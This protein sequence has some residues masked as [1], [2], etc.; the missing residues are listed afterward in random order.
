MATKF[1][2]SQFKSG[3]LSQ[4]LDIQLQDTTSY[5]AVNYSDGAPAL[6]VQDNTVDSISLTSKDNTQYISV[7]DA[8]IQISNGSGLAFAFASEG[9]RLYDPSDSSHYVELKAPSISSNVTLTLPATDG[10]VGQVLTTDG[11]G[12]LSWEDA[13]SGSSSSGSAGAVQI[14]NGSGGFTSEEANFFYNTSTN[15]VLIAN[16]TSGNYNLQVTSDNGGIQISPVTSGLSGALNAINVTGSTTGNLNIG[17]TNSNAGSGANSR[18]SLNTASGAG[19]PFILFNVGDTGYVAGIDNSDSDT[20][21]IGIGSNPSTMTSNSINIRGNKVGVSGQTSPTAALHLPAGT[22][23]AETAPLKFTTG[24]AMTTPEDGAL[25]Y[26]SSHLYFTIGSTRYQLDQQVAGGGTPI[27]QNGNSLGAAMTIGTNDAYALNLETNGNTRI[28]VSSAGEIDLGQSGTQRIL[29]RTAASSSSGGVEIS[30]TSTSSTT[31]VATKITGPSYTASSNDNKTVQITNSYTRSSGASGAVTAL[32]INPTVNLS[33]S[34]AGA[35]V[36]IDVTP[37]LTSLTGNFYGLYLNYSNAN[38]FGIFQ[39]GASTLNV[40]NGKLALGS[41]TS[42]TEALNV[43]GNAVVAGQYVSTAFGITDGAGFTVNWNNGNVQ[44]VT[45]QA[46]RTPTFSNPK[47]GGRY[48]LIVIQG[49]GGSK[50]ITWPTI[51]WRG[52][53]APTLTTAAGK[54]DIITLVYA[55]GSY[56]GDASLNY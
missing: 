56:Y 3:I 23:S 34:A 48:I 41:T 51:K 21:R 36:G 13:V 44:Y 27:V 20:F 35:S 15:Q 31:D 1:N 9:F 30:S 29:L 24:T 7:L 28:S 6:Y 54:A 46:N 38:A 11:S 37:T 43:T 39:S 14:S 22:A 25:E 55:N 16:S 40:L 8:G 49:T 2:P 12:V 50:L 52:G 17:V 32:A 26:H 10:L 18:L 53:T 19:D 45:I 5:F 33:G 42:P 47:E 4:D